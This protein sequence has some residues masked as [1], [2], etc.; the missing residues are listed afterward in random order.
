MRNIIEEMESAIPELKDIKDTSENLELVP[1][2]N[3]D[4]RI[5]SIFTHNLKKY[6]QALTPSGLEY[7]FHPCIIMHHLTGG[8]TVIEINRKKYLLIRKYLMSEENHK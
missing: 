1:A 6:K 3:W 2:R 7:Y 5:K 4:M 8:E